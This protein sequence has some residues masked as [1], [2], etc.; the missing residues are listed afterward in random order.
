MD[1]LSESFDWIPVCP[2]VGIGMGVPRPPIRLV[3][4]GH[5][6]HAVGVE[7]AG[8]DVTEALTGYANAL[9]QSLCSISG[10]IFKSRSPSCGL[11]DAALFDESGIETGLT[12][13]VF[14][15]VIRR[16]YPGL[17]V[18]D[19]RQLQDEDS[20]RLFLQQVF[21]CWQEQTSGKG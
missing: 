14:A 6:T 19:E 16:H 2:E 13:G 15:S 17:P 1:I 11:V 10:Y 21:A 20:R 4:M 7:D 8:N 12:S 5:S 18:T 3:S 9:E